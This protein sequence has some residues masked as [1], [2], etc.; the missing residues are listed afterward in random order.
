MERAVSGPVSDRPVVERRETV[1]KAGSEKPAQSGGVCLH[2]GTGLEGRR[3]YC[4]DV[5]RVRAY[6]E[7]K[8][9][10]MVRCECCLGTGWVEKN[11]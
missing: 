6:R 9:S 11:G 7:R 4:G 3:R 2:C 5:C 10:G 1:E 8:K